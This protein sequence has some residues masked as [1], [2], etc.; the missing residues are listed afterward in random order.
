[1]DLSR[2]MLSRLGYEVHTRT[3]PIEA[4]E[5]FR[6]N[7]ERFNLVI[8]DMTMPGMTGLGLAKKLNEISPGI[9]IVLCTG[10]SDQANEHRA[11]ALGIRAFLLKP[12]LMHDL[13]EAVRK[14]LDGP[15]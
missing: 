4:L 11:H 6:A 7:P 13:A 9:P 10:F 5:A 8:T 3:S 2:R 15:R 14:A 12:L 1:V